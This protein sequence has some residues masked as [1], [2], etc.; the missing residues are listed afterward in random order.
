MA[1]SFGL[2][3]PFSQGYLSSKARRSSPVGAIAGPIKPEI[4]YAVSQDH[5]NLTLFQDQTNVSLKRC[6]GLLL[7]FV[8]QSC[9]ETRGKGA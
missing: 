7:F 6:C 5:P 9:T 1:E 2:A 3:S 8:F 4:P